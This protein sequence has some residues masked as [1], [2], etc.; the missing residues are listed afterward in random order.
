VVDTAVRL[1]AEPIDAYRAIGQIGHVDV[2]T[3]TAHG[4]GWVA[5]ETQGIALF[6]ALRYRDDFAAALRV[7]VNI[8]GDSDSTGSVTGAILGA[9][10]GAEAIPQGWRER[11]AGAESPVDLGSRLAAIRDDHRAFIK[12]MA[13]DLLGPTRRPLTTPDVDWLLAYLPSLELIERAV[14]ECGEIGPMDGGEI[15]R[16]APASAIDCCRGLC[17]G[18]YENG[19]IVVFDW[20]SW[21]LGRQ[22][23]DH[24]DEIVGADLPTLRRLCTTLARAEHMCDGAFDFAIASGVLAAI[25]RR[26]AELRRV[27]LAP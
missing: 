5:E 20:P 22:L 2:E 10:L 6:C 23:H 26:L 15:T 9:A 21:P 14:R 16:R 24:P 3:P 19:W 1:A 13:P 11:V 25:V 27:G 12:S 7:A 18:L 17:G 4:K 8:S